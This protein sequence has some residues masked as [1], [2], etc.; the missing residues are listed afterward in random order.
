MTRSVPGPAPAFPR[1]E[2]TE[3]RRQKR[4]RAKTCLSPQGELFLTPFLPSTERVL[5]RS[6]RTPEPGVAFFGLPFLAKQK[7]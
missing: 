5:S 4:I 1:E 7:R 6:E 3:E 2:A